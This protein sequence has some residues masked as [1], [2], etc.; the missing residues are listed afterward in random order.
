MTALQLENLERACEMTVLP[1]PKA[2]GMAQV[3]PNTDLNQSKEKRRH[4]NENQHEEEHV[5]Q[6]RYA[7]EERVQDTLTSQQ[8]LIGRHLVLERTRRTHRPEVRQANNDLLAS[9][10]VLQLGDGVLL[11]KHRENQQL[12]QRYDEDQ[13]EKQ[14]ADLSQLTTLNHQQFTQT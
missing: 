6:K 9:D 3:P 4:V 14:E 8:R 1:Q 12:S 13:K 2:P 11:H 5:N 10:G 7:R